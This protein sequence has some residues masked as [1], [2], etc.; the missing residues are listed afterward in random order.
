MNKK[1]NLRIQEVLEVLDK[2]DKEEKEYK[3]DKAEQWVFLFYKL[4]LAVY[5]ILHK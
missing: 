5:M 1:Y 2:E 4:E 3:E